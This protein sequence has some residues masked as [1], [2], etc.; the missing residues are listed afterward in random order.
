MSH[1]RKPAW[2]KVE[3]GGS[4]C[5][6]VGRVLDQHGLNTVCEQAG[7]PNKGECFKNGTATFMLLGNHCTR[8]CAFCKVTRDLPQPVNPGEPE[9]VG[10]AAAEMGLRHVVVTSVT[11]DDLPDGGAGH[12]AAT[13]GAIRTHAPNTGVEVLVPD[14]QGD[15]AAL[16]VVLDSRPDILNHNVE[17]V[18]ELYAEI[19]PMAIFERSVGLLRRA[20][21][22]APGI[23]TKSGFMLGLGEKEEQVFMLLEVLRGAG[24]DIV[25]IGQY[26]QPSS[27]HYPVKE[28]V[29]PDVFSK[30]KDA[31]LRL[32]IPCVSS[33]PLIRSSY[34][35]E[36]DFR[37][38]NR[39][40]E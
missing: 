10:R 6:K 1:L 29:R 34:H 36:E 21:E 33:G 20:K 12:F 3:K 27:L 32:G 26:L 11:R 18:P 28:Y 30:Y 25:T 13:V 14:F 22:Y 39:R 15:E 19:R 40:G 4:R 5:G 37:K 16:R 2:L 7:C 8:N 35:A 24:C 38:L 23:Y 9:H 17:T 31:A